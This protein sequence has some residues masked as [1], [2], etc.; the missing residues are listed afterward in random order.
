[1]TREKG[2]TL[3]KTRASATLFT[4]SL[5]GMIG[6]RTQPQA[7]NCLRHGTVIIQRN[8][9]GTLRMEQEVVVEC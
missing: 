5:Y 6:D 8:F 9:E 2:S 3:R 4:A 1:M 7:P